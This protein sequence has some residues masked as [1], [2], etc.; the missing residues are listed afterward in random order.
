MTKRLKLSND[1]FEE[2]KIEFEK[3]NHQMKKYQDWGKN[4]DTYIYWQNHF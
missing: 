4:Y 3:S 1:S 2:I